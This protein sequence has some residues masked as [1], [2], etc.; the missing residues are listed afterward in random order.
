MLTPEQEGT[1][2]SWS[3]TVMTDSGEQY[4][5]MPYYLKHLGDS[6]YE[7]LRF[8]QLP[9]EVKDLILAN[10]GIKIPV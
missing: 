10:H 5:Y 4:L 8:D 6:V 2:K 1:I 3:K 7:Y 9:E